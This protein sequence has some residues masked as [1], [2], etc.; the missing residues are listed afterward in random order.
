MK[1]YFTL[2]VLAIFG[3]LFMMSCERVIDN[4]VVQQDNDTY[5]QMK[6]VTGTFS[7]TNNYALD[8]A[9][10]IPSSDVVLVY[11]NVNSNTSSGAVWQLIPK[12]FFLSN[13]RELDYNFVFNTQRVQVTTEANFDQATMVPDEKATYLNNQTFRIVLVPASRAARVA[14]GAAKVDYNDYNAVVKYFNLTE[15]K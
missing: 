4:T 10:N 3:G 8:Q 6:D 15:P 13:N 9:I 7:N 1:K 11:R 12:T 2:M 5:P 14:S